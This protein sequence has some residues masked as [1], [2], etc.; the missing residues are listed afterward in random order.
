MRLQTIFLL[1]LGLS[2]GCSPLSPSQEDLADDDDSGDDDDDSGDDD[3]DSGE[4]GALGF[5]CQAAGPCIVDQEFCQIGY[6]G[7]PPSEPAFTCEAM[8]APCLANPSCPCIVS[9]LSFPAETCHSGPLGGDTVE[10]YY[11]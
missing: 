7:V 2:V 4:G 6:P 9:N 11:P 5:D 1:L 10:I 3:D 8:P